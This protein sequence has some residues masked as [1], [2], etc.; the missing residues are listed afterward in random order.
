MNTA[1]QPS[2]S[3]AALPALKL[4]PLQFFLI[5]RIEKFERLEDGRYTTKVTSKRTDDYEN[6]KVF[7]IFSESRIG[8]KGEE[9]KVIVQANSYYSTRSYT[10]KS[11]GE[12]KKFE[13]ANT[14]F[15][16]IEVL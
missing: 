4:L 16:L 14:R 15:D 1:V 11:T 9:I 7:K 2:A 3:S 12:Q 6:T 10:D 13:D 8:Q 5:G